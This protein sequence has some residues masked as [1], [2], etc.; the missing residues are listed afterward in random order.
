MQYCKSNL[1]INTNELSS[2]LP[3]PTNHPNMT[4]HDHIFTNYTRISLLL[5]YLNSYET[6]NYNHINVI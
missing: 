4:E 1:S 5:I 3:K 6:I 2:A